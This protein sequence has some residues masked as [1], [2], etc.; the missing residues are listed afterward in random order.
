[1]GL[2]GVVSTQL[3]HHT[4]IDH[5]LADLPSFQAD[6]VSLRRRRQELIA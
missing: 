4:F 6:R 3:W 1:M 5:G 2:V